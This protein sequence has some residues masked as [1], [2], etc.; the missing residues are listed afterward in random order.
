MR[1]RRP[2]QHVL[3][4]RVQVH[5]R[6]GCT[7]RCHIPGLLVFDHGNSLTVQACSLTCIERTVSERCGCFRPARKQMYNGY[8]RANLRPCRGNEER[9]AV[10]W[11]MISSRWSGWRHCGCDVCLMLTG[12]CYE[13]IEEEF[14][15]KT[16]N[17]NCRQPCRCAASQKWNNAHLHLQCCVNIL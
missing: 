14:E 9:T 13:A 2:L 16:L 5:D 1:R 15:A 17:C 4:R 6:G 7:R 8:D 10:L 11:R 3:Q 12:A